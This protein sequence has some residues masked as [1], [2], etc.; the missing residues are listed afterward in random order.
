MTVLT[1]NWQDVFQGGQDFTPEVI[2]MLTDLEAQIAALSPGGST[3]ADVTA[4]D[5][6]IVLHNTVLHP[7]VSTGTLDAIATL[8]PPT[9][10]V[11]LNGQKITGL[12]PGV[13]PTDAANMSQVGGGGG[14]AVSSVFAR[15]GAVVALSGDYTTAIVADSL[16]KRYVTDAQKTVIGNTSGTNTG[17][18]T[19]VSGNAGTAT[20]LATAR[21]LDGQPFDGSADITVI[22]PGTRAAA[23]KTTPVDADVIPLSD[24][25]A[26]N[27]LKKVAWSAIKATLKTYF[28]TVY[29]PLGA[30]VGGDLTGTLPNPVV[31]KINGTALGT[32]SGATAGQALEWSGSAW[33]PGAVPVQLAPTAV[34][35]S[36][37]TAG[38]G[39]YVPCD[40]T[41]AGF[42]VTLPTAPADK[43]TIGVKVV[44]FGSAHN[45]TV[46]TGGSDVI[47]KTSGATSTSLTAA[48]QS[49]VM[50]Y[51]ASGAIWYIMA[52]TS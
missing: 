41:S 26:S 9:A 32:L 3:V 51:K 30:S 27:V 15:T 17:D 46:A 22:A 34:K 36:G 8:H 5:A 35:T 28:D 42:T 1:R 6:S 31:G 23:T 11:S 2:Q 18:Q 19:T 4:F 47:D 16:N 29:V 40:T 37:Y 33:I 14:G 49:V 52:V 7:Q 43:T 12:A 44:T 20:K 13:N 38:A 39:E 25:A 45:V 10:A 21:N 48:G 50:Q 24:S